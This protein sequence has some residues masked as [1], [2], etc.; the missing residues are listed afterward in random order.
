MEKSSR[1]VT[2][3]LQIS[4]SGKVL[5]EILLPTTPLNLRSGKIIE[6]LVIRLM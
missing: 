4:S 2:M 1:V 5:I 6:L 3:S